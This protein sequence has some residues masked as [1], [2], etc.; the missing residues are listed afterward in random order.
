MVSQSALPR[1]KLGRTGLEVTS[2]GFGA[3]PLGDL[4]L[5]LDDQTAIDAACRAFELG[6]NLLDTSPHYGNGLSEH[7]CGNVPRKVWC[8][9]P[10]S[11]A[12]WTRF[13]S[14]R[15]GL[16]LLVDTRTGPSSTIPMTAPCARSSSRCCGLAPTGSTFC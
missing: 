3:A 2:L 9:A 8:F 5:E 13:T 10:K 15:L 7:R 1:R 12:G 16:D 4:R 6:I 11:V 14:R